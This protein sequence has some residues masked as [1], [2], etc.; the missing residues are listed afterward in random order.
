MDTQYT[1]VVV[2]TK[3]LNINIYVG[4]D[5]NFKNKTSENV[6]NTIIIYIYIHYTLHYYLVL[7]NSKGIRTSQIDE[8][9]NK[10]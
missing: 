10:E 4:W 7:L 6:R 5:S 8:I 3:E 1:E 9:L 2:N